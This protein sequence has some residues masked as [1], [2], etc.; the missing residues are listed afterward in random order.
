MLKIIDAVVGA[1][2]EVGVFLLREE[3]GNPPDSWVTCSVPFRTEKVSV[4]QVNYVLMLLKTALI[5]LEALAEE[6]RN[7]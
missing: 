3:G 2:P 5:N 7:A 6:A 4:N 1:S